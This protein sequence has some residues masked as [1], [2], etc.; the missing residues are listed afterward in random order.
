MKRPL[1][2]ALFAFIAQTLAAFEPAEDGIYAVFDT[3]MGEFAV[4]LAYDGVPLTTA[5]FV[6]LAEGRIP[7]FDENGEATELAPYYD[8]TI[9]HRVVKNGLIQSGD[10]DPDDDQVNGPGYRIPDE[11]HPNLT[12][13]IPYVIAMANNYCFECEEAGQFFGIGENTGGSQFYLTVE[14]PAN[15]SGLGFLDGHFTIFG[16][17]ESGS[18]VLEAISSVAVDANEKPLEDVVIHTV[19]IVR[20]GAAAQAWAIENYE[21]PVVT[22]ANQR[23][24]L[25]DDQDGP[26]LQFPTQ[27]GEKLLLRQSADLA[28]WSE[29]FINASETGDH[30]IDLGPQHKLFLE[31]LAL[32]A[33]ATHEERL[34]NAVFKATL[35][36]HPLSGETWTFS[37]NENLDDIDDPNGFGV[38]SV[39]DLPDAVILGYEYHRLPNGGRIRVV[40]QSYQVITYYLRYT[41]GNKGSVFAWVDDYLHGTGSAPLRFPATGSFELVRP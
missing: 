3:S 37:F 14:P 26:A 6:G 24:Q 15:S 41:D 8:G 5:N 10:P 32:K 21:L 31:L 35:P 27:S 9:F 19:S 25:A 34:P 22:S 29:T 11:M 4:K 16:V 18:E 12:H 17:V 38:V 39:P 2:Y 7:Q 28:A 1:A 36:N 30:A 13:N 20:K 33:P 23:I 40:T